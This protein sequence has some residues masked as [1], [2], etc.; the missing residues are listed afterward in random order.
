YN[1]IATYNGDAKN[2]P[3]SA[4]C[5]SASQAV[6]VSKAWPVAS[7]TPTLVV[8]AIHGTALIQGGFGALTGTVTFTLTGPNDQF[9]SGPAL[10]TE[11]IPVNGAGSYDSGSFTPTV[12]GTYTYRIR[13]SGDTNNLGVGITSCLIQGDSITLTTGQPG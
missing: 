5:G 10:Y 3:V 2:N 9:C 6:I 8:T 11:T 7:V 1:W 12:A 13:Y 4:P